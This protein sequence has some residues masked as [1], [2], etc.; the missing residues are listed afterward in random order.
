MNDHQAAETSS[1]ERVVPQ[2]AS[3]AMLLVGSALII[4][5]LF[6][7]SPWMLVLVTV[8]AVVITVR[9]I[10]QFR[11]V[12]RLLRRRRAEPVNGAATVPPPAQALVLAGTWVVIAVVL[13]VLS[14]TVPS[15]FGL[16]SILTASALALCAVV[17]LVAYA[18]GRRRRRS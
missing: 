1:P 13:G 15:I 2:W 16:W 14:I 3:L 17:V 6:V 9:L 4:G 18:V 8:G 10:L 12:A 5:G 7:P 11:R